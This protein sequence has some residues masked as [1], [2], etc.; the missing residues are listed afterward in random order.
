MGD[1]DSANSMMNKG[2]TGRWK[3][4]FSQEMITQFEVW[5][6]KWMKYKDLKLK[7]EV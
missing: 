6:Q 5:E 4:I 1:A 3:T 2:K 7:F